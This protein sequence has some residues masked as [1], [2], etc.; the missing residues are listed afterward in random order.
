MVSS[1]ESNS[2]RQLNIVL[3]AQPHV[4]FVVAHSIVLY[5]HTLFL[6]PPV[7]W[8]ALPQLWHPLAAV[9]LWAPNSTCRIGYSGSRWPYLWRGVF[10]LCASIGMVHVHISS[11]VSCIKSSGLVGT[12]LNLLLTHAILYFLWCWT[13]RCIFKITLTQNCCF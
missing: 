1:D 6:C 7:P 10:Q 11:P 4:P 13:I 9:R 2:S 3:N 8:S 5:T 12:S